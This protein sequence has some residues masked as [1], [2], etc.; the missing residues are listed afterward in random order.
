MWFFPFKFLLLVI[1]RCLF[2]Q[3]RWNPIDKSSVSLAL[4]N[5]L[6]INDTKCAWIFF[7]RC[8]PDDAVDLFLPKKAIGARLNNFISF[9]YMTINFIMYF[10]L[11][12]CNTIKF[13]SI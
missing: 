9:F 11:A 1:S 13:K 10:M 8:F 2:P 5:S 6:Q 3:S 12:A 4:V 7:S